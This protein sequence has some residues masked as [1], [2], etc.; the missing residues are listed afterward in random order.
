MTTS[1]CR[2][3]KELVDRGVKYSTRHYAHYDCYLDAGK[4]L[5]DLTQWQVSQ[6]PFRLIMDRGLQNEVER[7]DQVTR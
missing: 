3:C 7:I 2:F 4:S 5:S 1:T 6:F